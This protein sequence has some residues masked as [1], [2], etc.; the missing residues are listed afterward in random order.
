MK[1]ILIITSAYGHDSSV[2]CGKDMSVLSKL[3][4][5]SK[6][7]KVTV[8]TSTLSG[9]L[10][11]QEGIACYHLNSET[12]EAFTEY[13]QVLIDQYKSVSKGFLK[14]KLRWQLYWLNKKID[15]KV[16]IGPHW[17]SFF[18]LKQWMQ[19]YQGKAFDLLISV[20]YPFY[21]QEYAYQVKKKL[22]IKKWIPYLLDPYADNIH[23]YQDKR[24][25]RGKKENKIFKACTNI[26]TV[27]EIVTHARYSP[28]KKFL[29]KIQYIPTHL[30]TDNTKYQK[31][32]NTDLIHF[33]YTGLFYPDIRNPEKLLQ[34][35]TQLPNNYILNLYSRGCVDIVTRYKEI[36]G[37]RLQINDYILDQEEY[38]K[39][40]GQAD[41]LVDVGNTVSNQVPSKILTYCSFGKPIIHFKNCKNEVVGEKF[42]Q[43]PL[44]NVVDYSNDIS[45][46]VEEIKNIVKKDFGK[47]VSYQEIK[48]NFS[49]CTVEY[50]AE[51]IK[52]ILGE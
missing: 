21:I 32:N 37:D 24:K 43:Y 47:A 27:E 35:F 44:F 5:T 15:K 34:Y 16:L 4:S 29:Q 20:S 11:T 50:V 49:E 26:F 41:F 13:R 31:K 48:D 33:V 18:S 7:I 22:H 38:N 45:V 52:N 28:I 10:E 12:L 3:L 46:V 1:N 42:Q 19:E 51:K 8:L 9:G 6:K 23:C 14:F 25:R 39:M 40:I 36:L 2:P 30:M 17:I